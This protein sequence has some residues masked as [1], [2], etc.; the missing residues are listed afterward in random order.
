MM[1][2]V[3]VAVSEWSGCRGFACERKVGTGRCNTVIHPQNRCKGPRRCHFAQTRW[4]MWPPEA[5]HPPALIMKFPPKKMGSRASFFLLFSRPCAAPH[6]PRGVL[7]VR[8]PCL[9]E[10]GAGR[11]PSAP[12]RAVGRFTGICRRHAKQ[13]QSCAAHSVETTVGPHSGLRTYHVVLGAVAEVAV[14]PLGGVDKVRGLADRRKR[15]RHASGHC[16]ALPEPC[17]EHPAWKKKQWGGG[18]KQWAMG[19]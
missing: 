5:A 14:P 15:D 9:P 6:A 16:A 19:A 12:L 8:C 1:V 3:V 18:G 17:G 7:Y 13:P 4:L 11:G 2:V 10:S